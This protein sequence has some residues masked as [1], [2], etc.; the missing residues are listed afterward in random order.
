MVNLPQTNNKIP[1]PKSF[2]LEIDLTLN[3]KAVVDI[4]IDQETGSYISGSGN[5][6]LFME[7]D[8]EGEFN[9]FGDFITTEGVYI[10]GSCTN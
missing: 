7:I 6:N 3:N 4:T 5:G 2:D 1:N 9:I 8:S 10:Q